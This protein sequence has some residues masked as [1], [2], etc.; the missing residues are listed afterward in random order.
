[1]NPASHKRALVAA[2][3]DHLATGKPPRIPA[4]GELVWRWFL[5]LN[6]T[7]G[8]GF[9]GP[10][11]IGYAEI[12]AYRHIT[13][14]PIEPRHVDLIMALDRAF[15]DHHY[16]SNRSAPERPVARQA[17]TAQVFDAMFR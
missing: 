15:L 1:M 14:W 17:M 16:S 4:G 13:R 11:P 10:L 7:R 8:Q 12:S 3:A 9:A 5:D 2:L 6:A